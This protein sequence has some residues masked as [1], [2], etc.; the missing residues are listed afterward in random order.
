MDR[1][2]RNLRGLSTEVGAACS[3]WLSNRGVLSQTWGRSNRHGT[4][5]KPA[6]LDFSLPNDR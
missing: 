2:L 1:E 4:E 3:A 5:V 6:E